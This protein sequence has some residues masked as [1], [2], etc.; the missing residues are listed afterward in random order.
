MEA[1]R[2]EKRKV[3][4][5]IYQ[6]K[7]KVIE[8]IGKTINE[9]VNGNRKLFWKEVSNVKGGKVENCSK[10]KD[11]NGMMPQGDDEV[12]RIWKKYFEDLYNIDTQEEI[13]VHMCGFDGI[14]SGNYLGGERN[15]KG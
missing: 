12:R 11:M 6:N 1:Y 9:D 7:K 15:W 14:R 13:A 4:R 8:Q 2:E 3:E 10:I 5:C